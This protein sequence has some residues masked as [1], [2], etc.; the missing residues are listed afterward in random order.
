[1]KAPKSLRLNQSHQ[2]QTLIIAIKRQSTCNETGLSATSIATNE[3]VKDF[4]VVITESNVG[5]VAP[6]NNQ[7][8]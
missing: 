2:P 6:R 4:C 8:C 1:V 5:M 3:L 7:C